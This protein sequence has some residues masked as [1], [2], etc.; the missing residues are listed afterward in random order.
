M[1]W[2]VSHFMAQRLGGIRSLLNG[3]FVK[4]STHAK[5]DASR[6]GFMPRSWKMVNS[7]YDFWQ[8]HLFRIPRMPVALAGS[9][10]GGLI[11]GCGCD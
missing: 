10:I 4:I 6:Y 11:S 3:N 8:K 1:M 5:S 9:G 7:K 2:A